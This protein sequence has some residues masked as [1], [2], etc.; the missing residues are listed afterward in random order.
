MLFGES[1]GFEA[2]SY[3]VWVAAHPG[4]RQ[5]MTGF[6]PLKQGTSGLEICICNTKNAEAGD[7]G[8]RAV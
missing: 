7:G 3:G 5:H 6:P 2:R 8:V 1:G 4:N